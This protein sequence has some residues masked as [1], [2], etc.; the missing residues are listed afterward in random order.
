M[1][2]QARPFLRN[3]HTILLHS[4]NPITASIQQAQQAHGH[5][6]KTGLSSHTHLT[7]KLL[8]LY[9]HLLRFSDAALLLDSLADPD[10]F[11]FSTLISA[12]SK[13]GLFGQSLCLFRRMLSLGLPPDSFIFP[14]TLKACAG[15]SAI[16]TGRQV[17]GLAWASGFN[18]DCFVQSSLVHMY[19]KCDEMWDAHRVFDGMME[20]NV[21]S[22]SAMVAGYA[23]QGLVDEAIRLF[24]RMQ[25][26]GV[27]PNLVSWN[28]LIS[29]FN[30]NRHSSESVA[31]L[32]KMH[33]QGFKP[34]ETS[35]S[36][37]LPAVGDLEDLATGK[38]I[39]GYV[40]KQG[41]GSDACVVSALV[42]MYGKCQCT[43]EM[44]QLFDEMVGIDVGSCN[45]LVAGLSH[46]GLVDDA[47]RVFRQFK[48]GGIELN[49][50]SWTSIVASCAQNGKDIEALELFREMQLV[51]VKPNLVTIPCLLPACANIAALIHGKAVHGFSLRR[52][53][54]D[55]VYI[56]SALIDMYAKCGRIG[57]AQRVFDGMPSR[58]V[59]SWNAIMGGYAMHGKGKE[60]MELFSLM[61]QSGQKPDFISFTC[62]LSACSQT[63]LT[64]EGF[65]Y[66]NNMSR[67]YGIMARMEHYA[68]MVSLL[69]RA[70]KL[71]E[72]SAMIK[73]MPFEPDACIWGALLSSCRV[74]GNVSLGEKAAESLFKLEPRNAG[75]YVLLSNIYAAKG[76]WDGVDRVREMMKCMGLRKNPGCSWIEMKNKVH[77]LLAGDT[78]HPQMT[79]ILERLGRLNMEMKKLGYLPNT[80][81]VLQD[82]EEQE[83]EHILC[84]HSEKLAIG[85]GLLN[86]P[87][88]SP[89]RVIKNLRICGDCHVAIKFISSFEEREIF[90]RDTNRFHHFKNGVCSCGDYW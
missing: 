51:G 23:R 3:S 76:M 16:D 2:R 67:E 53:I 88:R 77:T 57:D 28:G 4:L 15:L 47:L 5:I 20:P 10:A 80:N 62:V 6:L 90:V 64:E 34:D 41:Y 79:Q 43:T 74:H 32:K 24:D 42:D 40:I 72:A 18:S 22:W 49:V 17:H 58:N 52:V 61:E 7:T 9:A 46:N 48:D 56:G 70:G 12:C 69:S 13:S 83:K 60:A 89:L 71:E 1:A 8:S 87:P 44:L 68:C 11:S 25:D 65:R 29:G 54:L 59:V 21:V 81:F 19:V 36:S 78:S 35:I 31:V 33:M 39:H 30:H 14:S 38:Q 86:T 84:R 26:S 27:E 50:V 75:N 73:E 66:F 63:G 45:A 85:L 55:D 37:V 82:V